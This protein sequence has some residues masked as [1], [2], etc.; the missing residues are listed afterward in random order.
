MAKTKKTNS[1]SKLEHFNIFA[2]LFFVIAFAII[3][4]LSAITTMAA[5]PQPV[6]STP[7]LSLSPSSASVSAGSTLAVQIWMD[8]GVSTVNAV[9]ANLSY[10][11]NKFNFVNIDSAGTAFGVEA[12][13][14]GGNGTVNIARGSTA[15]LSGKQLVAT[16]NFTPLSSINK[17]RSTASVTFT[18]GTA[19][20][21]D[22]TNTSI[23]AATYGGSYRL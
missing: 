22:V 11:L 15:P 9:Q 8:S 1:P 6:R 17:H 3:T 23:L 7:N 4:S 13:S 5:K 10:P 19:L 16:V 2:G 12:Q 20:L 14:T 18:T 21:S